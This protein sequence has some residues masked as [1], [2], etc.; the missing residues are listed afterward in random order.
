M[1]RER[2]IEALREI[3]TEIE[4]G[5][6]VEV[7]LFR[8]EDAVGV[9]LAY[10]EVYGDSFP[11]DHVYNPEEVARRNDSE[12]QYT[13]VARTPRGEV[14]GLAGLF[15]NAPDPGV[16]E[17]GQLM[18][19]KSYRN[20]HV[21]TLISRAAMGDCALRIGL[22][23]VFCEAVCNH[24]ASQRLAMQEG[25]IPTGLEL[26]CM[27]AGAFE[28][29]GGV[30]RNV[31]L[32][33]LF[34]VIKP[35]RC[36]VCL[37][38]RYADVIE[39]MYADFGL[40]RDRLDPVPLSGVTERKVFPVEDAKLVRLTVAKAGGDL[41]SVAQQ[42]EAAFGGETLVQAYLNLGDH[43][44]PDAVRLLRERGYFFG[45]LLP[46]WFGADG[47]VLQ[48]IPREPEWDAIRLYGKKIKAILEFVRRDYQSI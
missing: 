2:Y 24:P 22:P 4:P 10:L 5:Q 35:A 7:G 13:I 21:A 43:A 40:V 46:Q 9:S 28:K 8:P 1:S 18:V 17:G 31:S 41:A 23:V 14:V 12:D 3:R 30:V 44:A 33:L 27:P 38:E 45:G 16:Y 26:E 48:K 32:A 36:S 20:S 42:A 34:R 39:A 15:R 37:P 47:M 19:L 29:E 25:L 6:D 11:I